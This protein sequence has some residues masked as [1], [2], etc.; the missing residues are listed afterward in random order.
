VATTASSVCLCS[1]PSV[2][3]G[4]S[5]IAAAARKLAVRPTNVAARGYSR[6]IAVR[7]EHERC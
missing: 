5:R 1:Y 3:L 4:R 7:G 6:T 2:M